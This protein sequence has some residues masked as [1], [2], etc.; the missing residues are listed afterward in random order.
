MLIFPQHS[1]QE[2]VDG[3]CDNETHSPPLG[4]V[5]PFFLRSL[6]PSSSPNPHPMILC[7]IV[8]TCHPIRHEELATKPCNAAL[9]DSG[10]LRR[11]SARDQPQ[12]AH[13]Q[14]R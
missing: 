5:S 12:A 8:C 13:V 4:I 3:Q 9:D 6:I 7:S 14:Q 10:G 1:G 11:T 2:E